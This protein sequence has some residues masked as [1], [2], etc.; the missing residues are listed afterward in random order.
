MT[1]EYTD[2]GGYVVTHDKPLKCVWC[3]SDNH[4]FQRTRKDNGAPLDI[5]HHGAICRQCTI[6][7]RVFHAQRRMDADYDRRVKYTADVQEALDA[8]FGR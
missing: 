6:D 5:N 3:G 4:L 2:D 7:E 8:E 1:R